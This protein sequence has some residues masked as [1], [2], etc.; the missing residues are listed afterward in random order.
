MDENVKKTTEEEKLLDAETIAEVR[1]VLE[2]EEA[3]EKAAEKAAETVA[4]AGSEKTAEAGDAAAAEKATEEERAQ[5][6]EKLLDDKTVAE[7]QKALEEDDPEEEYEDEDDEEEPKKKSKVKWIVL[8]VLLLAL[9]GGYSGVALYYRNYFLPKTTV[10]GIDVSKQDVAYVED[11]ILS[12]LD[13][14][15]LTIEGRNDIEDSFTADDIEME[16]DLGTG[17]SDALEAQNEWLWPMIMMNGESY[18]LEKALSF[19]E[20]K[21][22][23]VIADMNCMDKEKALAPE[24]AYMSEWSEDTGFTVIPEEENNLLKTD[25]FRSLIEEK[26]Y[27]LC[28]ELTLDELEAADAYEHPEIYRDD[29][30]LNSK[31]EQLNEICN[32]KITYTF[33]DEKVVLTGKEISEWVVFNKK[34]KAKLDEDKITEFVNTLA[35]T[36][37]TYGY[38]ARTFKTTYGPTVTVPEGDYGWWMNRGATKE[39]LIEAIKKGGKSK[40]TPVYYQTANAYGDEDWG[41][42]YVEINLTAQHLYLY[43][44]GKLVLDTAF[45]SGKPSIKDTPTGIFGITYKERAHTMEGDPSDPYRVETSFWMPFNGNV[46]MHDATWR[47]SFGGTLYKSGGSHGCV[48]LPYYATKKI[49]ETVSQGYPVICYRLSG[50]EG[51][52]TYNHTNKEIAQIGIDAIDRIGT[53][54]N[55]AACKKRVTWA[56]QV[57]T[58]LSSAQRSLVTNYKKLTEAESKLN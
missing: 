47:S 30:T 40:L 57:Y 1:K 18:T 48:N 44:D 7:V 15:G 43:K 24:D 41:D 5:E 14:Y 33:G 36:Y 54:T 52:P 22:D 35:R 26:I 23:A 4:E 8:G 13:D 46:G 19:N 16:M 28:S 31:V 49:Y 11:R 53:V 3:A 27:G 56:R 21:L 6:A 39:E 29:E 12:E 25:V 55:D 37:D 38:G 51:G 34:N 32:A 58:D 9:I 45:V 2:A 17:V 42:S 10:N 50:T 20:E